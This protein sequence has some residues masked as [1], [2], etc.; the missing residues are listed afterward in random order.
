MTRACVQV[1]YLEGDPRKHVRRMKNGNQGREG[2]ET[3]KHE[4]MGK[5]WLQ[6]GAELPETL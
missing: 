1:D 5:F 6:T 4:A 3:T 2:K